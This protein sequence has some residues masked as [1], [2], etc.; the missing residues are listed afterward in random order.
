MRIVAAP[1]TGTV[2]DMAASPPEERTT[3]LMV[4]PSAAAAR[5]VVAPSIDPA[6]SKVSGKRHVWTGREHSL[7]RSCLS[8]TGVLLIWLVL[9]APSLA[10]EVACQL[11]RM[12]GAKRTANRPL[13][14]SFC[15]ER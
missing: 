13:H 1:S 9:R 7:T 2:R 5:L 3:D 12:N 11:R 8:A 6:S 15:R 10:E 14:R 4:P